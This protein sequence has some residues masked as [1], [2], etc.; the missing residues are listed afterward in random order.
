MHIN[1]PKHWFKIVLGKMY[2]VHNIVY[3]IVHGENVNDIYRRNER[4]NLLK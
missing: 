1:K 4:N 3:G 2:V